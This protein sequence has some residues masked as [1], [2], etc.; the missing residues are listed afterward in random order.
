MPS[1][2][3]LGRGAQQWL[4]TTTSTASA[5]RLDRTAPSAAYLDFPCVRDTPDYKLSAVA[6]EPPAGL[7]AM[8]L[9]EDT[10]HLPFPLLDACMC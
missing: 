3:R 6:L 5:A 10:E 2:A 1:L 4:R 8:L 7:M 9:L